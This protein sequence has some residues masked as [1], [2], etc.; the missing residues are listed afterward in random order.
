VQQRIVALFLAILLAS[1]FSAG[2]GRK[3]AFALGGLAWRPG[4]NLHMDWYQACEWVTGLGGRWRM[5]TI[6]ELADL[7]VSGVNSSHWGPL[8]F[9]SASWIW[10]GEE[11]ENEAAAC[12]YFGG[13]PRLEWLNR[14][15]Y[16]CCRAV[17]VMELED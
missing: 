6:D 10:S 8:E 9:T 2:C 15:F 16:L 5:P 12:Y 3:D 14:D 4:P 1:S 17:A 13:A 11:G 7:Y